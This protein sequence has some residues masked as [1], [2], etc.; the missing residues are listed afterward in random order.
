MSSSSAVVPEKPKEPKDDTVDE[1]EEEEQGEGD[2]EDA[3]PEEPNEDGKEEQE[4]KQAVDPNQPPQPT[5]VISATDEN[6]NPFEYVVSVTKK[7]YYP[8][9]V[10]GRGAYATVFLMKDETG[11]EYAM[12]LENENKVHRLLL[13][14]KQVYGSLKVPEIGFVRP[15]DY[16]EVR[17]SQHG[18]IMPRLGESLHQ[19]EN[20]FK[21]DF[22]TVA[23]IGIQCL[24][25]LRTLHSYGFVHQD[26]KPENFAVGFKDYRTIYLIDLGT[27]IRVRDPI[28]MQWVKQ[29][30]AVVKTLRAGNPR[31][32]SIAAHAGESPSPW[33]DLQSLAYMLVHL[34]T[35]KLPWDDET[36][37]TKGRK[38]AKLEAIRKKKYNTLP[39]DVCNG[40]PMGFVRFLK[41]TYVSDRFSEPDYDAL[42]RT[43]GSIIGAQWDRNKPFDLPGHHF[44][45][46]L[47]FDSIARLPPDPRLI[48]SVYPMPEFNHVS[49]QM[50]SG[51]DM[52]QSNASSFRRYKFSEATRTMVANTRISVVLHN[53]DLLSRAYNRVL[54]EHVA[55]RTPGGLQA[56]KDSDVQASVNGIAVAPGNYAHDTSPMAPTTTAVVASSTPKP[57]VTISTRPPPIAISAPLRPSNEPTITSSAG[58]PRPQP[59]ASSAPVVPIVPTI[60]VPS[61]NSVSFRQPSQSSAISST[62]MMPVGQPVGT[63]PQ[64][65]L[66]YG[67]PPLIPTSTAVPHHHQVSTVAPSGHAPQ[68]R[69]G[70]NS[71]PSEELVYSGDSYASPMSV[72][73]SQ[74]KRK[75]ATISDAGSSL[76]TGLLLAEFRRLYYHNLQHSPV[77]FFI[78]KHL[79][80]T[81]EDIFGVQIS[82]LQE[83][84]PVSTQRKA[85]ASP[86]PPV[87]SVVYR[88]DPRHQP[89]PHP[90][91]SALPNEDPM[92]RSRFAN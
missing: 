66:T 44:A 32:A 74:S 91:Q 22:V 60:P 12:K 34:A 71:Q 30:K 63:P 76:D 69:F 38:L 23:R 46:A 41:D 21:M 8:I 13:N 11:Q 14:E 70:I 19:L 10:L 77:P 58:E 80:S 28:T 61:A 54:A 36:N 17:P 79:R 40:L 64:V 53:R 83:D 31:F 82:E 75:L 37:E 2:G 39:S 24:Y 7:K 27:C 49:E 33:D 86:P 15:I 73:S 56:V 16:C 88:P 59:N 6:G 4:G 9:G 43:L 25:R 18:L 52:T 92:K 65:Y 67:P 55:M 68:P 42:A 89:P 26:I 85:L 1:E 3:G 20:H 29:R 35:E 47:A 78:P 81:Y 48:T 57:R 84:E 5:N 51:L 87:S 72:G 50:S 45:W 62:A 90:L